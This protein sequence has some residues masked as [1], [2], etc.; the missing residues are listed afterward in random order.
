MS[1]D[2]RF[3][4]LLDRVKRGTAAAFGHAE[5]PFARVVEVLKVARSASF[6]PVYQASMP[7]LLLL[8]VSSNSL[9]PMT[10]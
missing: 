8:A 5:A 10:L 6:T 3:G 2:P 7:L 4:T 1:G 9:L